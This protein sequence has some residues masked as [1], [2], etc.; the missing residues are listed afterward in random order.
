MRFSSAWQDYALLDCTMGERL[1]KWGEYILIRPDP[2]V[3]WNTPRDDKLWSRA[4]ARYVRSSAGGGAWQ[5]MNKKMPQSWHIV[6]EDMTFTVKTMGFKHTGVFPEQACNWDLLR[7]VIKRAGRPVRVLNLFAYTGCATC[8]ALSAGASCVHV[9]ASKGITELAKENAAQSGLNGG[10]VRFFVD[11]CFKL[12]EREKRRGNR[13]EVIIMDPPSYGRGP[14]GEVWK[15]ED[16]VYDLVGACRE[17]VADDALLFMVNSY[18]TGISP[19]SMEY[20]LGSVL[21][22]DLGGEVRAD[23]IGIPVK[24][25]GL[26]LPSGGTAVWSGQGLNAFVE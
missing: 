15:L 26:I 13:Y 1:E 10:N 7:R 6:Y 22:K 16:R 24:S 17:L 12:V 23:E 8:A 21:K 20:I 4:D 14:S 19:S 9:D 11:D 2:E 5:Y 18:T 25:S 3:I